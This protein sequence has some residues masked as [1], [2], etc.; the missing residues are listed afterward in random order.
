MNSPILEGRGA[1]E[2]HLPPHVRIALQAARIGIWDWNI[3]TGSIVYSE[4][5]KAIC[6]F[7]LGRPVTFQQVSDITHPEDH[8]RTS[9]MALRALDPSTR[10]QNEY[11]YRIRRADDGAVRWVE[12]YGEAIF[13]EIDG[14]EQAVR[15]IGTLKD[16]T[17]EKLAD[18]A[19][20]ESEA[21]L[22]L[23]MDAAQMAI[24]D[25][26]LEHDTMK[27]SPELNRICGFPPDA[28]PTTQELREWY[29]PGERERIQQEGA[30][31]IGRG[32]TRFQSEF[33][34][35]WPNGTER[36]LRLRCQFAPSRDGSRRRVIGILHDVTDRKEG[37]E[38]LEL[39]AD[40][41]NHRAKNTLAII[42]TIAR[43]TFRDA[44]DIDAALQTFNS[45]LRALAIGNDLALK[46]ST[47]GAVLREVI[48][49]ALEPFQPAN[50]MAFE[51]E[52]AGI[53]IPA[54]RV[55]P[56]ALAMNELATNASKYGA[57]AADSGRIAIRWEPGENG[58]VLLHWQETGGPTVKPP[59]QR[60]FGSRLL[61]RG[62]FRAANDRVCLAYPPAGFICR[63][64]LDPG[65]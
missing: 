3:K 58:T 20:A 41:L 4:L 18:D 25:L 19:L 52:G 49:S 59:T 37:E 51:L 10:E 45:R 33:R 48:L 27:H 7:P 60:G 31:A 64:E 46:G 44:V 5:A 56:L 42:Q 12:A 14:R 15:Y 9:A 62:L 8:P 53:H 39:L 13:E 21:T 61:E 50:R 57:L 23:A 26:D 2:V 32:E 35:I 47:S 28:A 11:R 1:E 16:I 6:G 24:W 30:E 36:W 63:I 22:R 54:K 29:A 34:Y 40:E 65:G 17:D 38:R 55:A 43:Q